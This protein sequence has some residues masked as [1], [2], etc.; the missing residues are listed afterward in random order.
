[1]SEFKRNSIDLYLFYDLLYIL[2]VIIL[3][4][5]IIAAIII[6]TFTVLS[7]EETQTLFDKKNTCF[8]CGKSKEL[9]NT[10]YNSSSSY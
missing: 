7:N 5:Q 8:I 2:I 1:V 6:D 4:V 3:I 10:K 9:F